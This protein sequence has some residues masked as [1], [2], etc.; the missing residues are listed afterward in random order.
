MAAPGGGDS[1]PPPPSSEEDAFRKLIS[2]GGKRKVPSTVPKFIKKLDE[3]PEIALQ[4][5]QSIKIA[6]A[7]S[8]RGLVGQF[9]GLWPSAKTTD[10][11][12][13]RNWKP[14]LKQG[15]TCYPLSSGFFLF[16]F[17]NKEDKDLIF[18]NGPYF[19]GTQGLYLNRWTP[20]FDPMVELPKEVPVWVRLPNLPVHCWNYEALQKIGNGIGKFIDKA[21][22]KSIYNCAR[23]CVEVDLEAGLPEAVKLT[24]GNWSHYQKLDYEHLPFKCRTCQE[25]GHFQRNCPKNQSPEKEDAEGWQ[26]VKKSKPGPKSKDPRPEQASLPSS[27]KPNPQ[28]V[29]PKEGANKPKE[30]LK[31]P[32]V[33]VSQSPPA[34]E[35]PI[36]VNETPPADE[37]M[38]SDEEH[39]P[40]DSETGADTDEGA[41]ET[42]SSV[43]TPEKVPRGRKPERKKREE[44][45]YRDVTAG[46]QHTIPAM[47]ETRS[48]KKGKA[49]K[50]ATPPPP[51]LNAF[52][53]LEL[54]RVGK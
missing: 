8:E 4:E 23:I 36:P 27:S 11:W 10:A 30:T 38:K 17:I 35:N 12:V 19:M 43:G 5:T 54:Q 37:P 45:S 50:G 48:S 21:D 33:I 16:E 18:R 13:Q 40:L 22:N 6:L 41:T 3:I 31:E 44:K 51:V 53:L 52:R 46:F 20:D 29:P 9:M 24:V 2:S 25:H 1:A 42:S 7:L 32:F 14:H 39:N 15:V 34:P 49:S 28:K 26:K 47:I